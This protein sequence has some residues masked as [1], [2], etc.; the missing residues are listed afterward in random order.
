MSEHEPLLE[1]ARTA[2]NEPL[3]HTVDGGSEW[4][5]TVAGF[6]RRKYLSY[7]D[8][9]HHQR[10]KL[11]RLE[12]N[13]WIVRYHAAYGPLLRKRLLDDDIS[14]GLSVLCLGARVGTEVEAFLACGCYAIGVDI[15]PGRENKYV[16]HGDFHNLVFASNSIDVL[17]TNALDHSFDLHRVISEMIRVVKPG[18]LLIAEVMKGALEGNPVIDEYDCCHWDCIDSLMKELEHAG[19][20]VERR[21]SFGEPWNGDHCVLRAYK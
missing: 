4:H 16:V 12:A 1:E 19:F 11:A 5:E 15:N 8:Y 17:F 20:R 2:S 14:G 3:D 10:A 21:S 18:G 6:K 9:L 7:S 13:D